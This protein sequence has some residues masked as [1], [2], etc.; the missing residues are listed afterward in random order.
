MSPSLIGIGSDIG[1]QWGIKLPN[2]PT[3]PQKVKS[4]INSTNP[5][6]SA[7]PISGSNTP[8]TT[9]ANLPMQDPSNLATSSGDL[10][11]W[12]TD[13][14]S[15]PWDV[16]FDTMLQRKI[17]DLKSKTPSS[18]T[19][20]ASKPFDINKLGINTLVSWSANVW[21]PWTGQTPSSNPVILDQNK[22]KQWTT[23]WWG[24]TAY[25][26]NL[27]QDQWPKKLSDYT[28][29]EFSQLPTDQQAQL[30]I[31]DKTLNIVNQIRQVYPKETEW[32][33]DQSIFQDFYKQKPEEV[34]KFLQSDLE[35]WLLKIDTNNNGEMT[36]NN[37]NSI[38][39]SLQRWNSLT[40]PA[41]IKELWS[42][43]WDAI[44][45]EWGTLKDVATGKIDPESAIL[46]TVSN[47]LDTVMA[48][49]SAWIKSITKLIPWDSQS[50]VEDFLQNT[51][52]GQS[53][54]A[55]IQTY[56][57]AAK[58]HPE[59][60]DNIAA[61]ANIA[62]NAI[63]LWAESKVADSAVWD[64]LKVA[65]D[66]VE[67][68]TLAKGITNTADNVVN[69]VKNDW[70]KTAEEAAG[71]IV[72]WNAES[73][74]KA[75]SALQSDFVD[76]KWVKTY[77]DLWYRL[78]TAQKDIIAEKKDYLSKDQRTFGKDDTTVT[79]GWQ[80]VNHIQ[81]GLNDLKKIYETDRNPSGEAQVKDRQ[82][83]LDNWSLT[84]KDMDAISMKYNADSPNAWNRQWDVLQSKQAIENTRSWIKDTYRNLLPDDYAK[85]LDK[86]YSEVT[87]T[88]DL[89]DKMTENVNKAKQK[90]AVKWPL[91]KFWQAIV[92]VWDIASLW[93]LSAIGKAAG[94]TL[95]IKWWES[96]SATE[97]EA[98]L[99]KLLKIQDRLY[100]ATNAWD[101]EG[102]EQALKELNEIKALTYKWD[103]GETPNTIL[104]PGKK[105]I[106][107]HQWSVREWQES[108]L[109][110]TPWTDISMPN[111]WPVAPTRDVLEMQAKI[112]NANH[113][114][115]LPEKS[116]WYNL[117]IDK[118]PIVWKSTKKSIIEIP[119]K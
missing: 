40:V 96:L 60:A 46:Q 1:L 38:S 64:A 19:L 101:K 117:W 85:L 84:T 62:L 89:I 49:I 87:Q 25:I 48:P 115:S 16:N 32:Q 39:A 6:T 112:E 63:W 14:I 114:K 77:S 23:T 86:Q 65:G 81:D 111:K 10:Q 52:A 94:K 29:Q 66:T 13:N 58:K 105:I 44:K 82:K 95:W 50:G 59:A 93:N 100:T 37:Q 107:G 61:I 36:L 7:A 33:T 22:L 45:N 92:K 20:D 41:P 99:P 98:Q 27:A 97:L 110:S 69:N 91:Q 104:S 88:K 83:K 119:W 11:W 8:A 67:N 75:S 17:Q 55:T 3:S 28:E 53:I 73:Q 76:T 12:T 116:Q 118:N 9:S 5:D 74:A 15:K 68:N 43:L 35:K 106:S 24:T 70:I 30:S 80:Q 54:A 103:L 102:A 4:A 90:S 71:K 72:Q 31:Q 51:S 108:L 26:S 56:Q 78:E 57:E 47:W 113:I 79:I 2:T 42:T 34:K 18:P 109:W 21:A